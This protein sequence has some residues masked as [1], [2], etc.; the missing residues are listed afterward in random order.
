MS[1][2]K[3]YKIDPR[4]EY[5]SGIRFAY[6]HGYLDTVKYLVSLP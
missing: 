5:N 3:E 6:K 4:A 2:P 1:L